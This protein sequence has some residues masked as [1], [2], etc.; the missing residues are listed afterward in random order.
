M[1]TTTHSS[2]N[3]AAEH[4]IDD[5][6]TVLPKRSG[7]ASAPPRRSIG[8]ISRQDVMVLVGAGVSSL[9][10]PMLLFGRLTPL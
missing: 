10:T 1:I 7:S 3:F 5:T 4:D 6:T 2:S 8:G 9:C